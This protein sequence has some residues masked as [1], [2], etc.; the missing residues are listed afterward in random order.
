MKVLSGVRMFQSPRTRA[1]PS[2]QWRIPEVQQLSTV[3][4]QHRTRQ[5]DIPQGR[6]HCHT[7]GF[8]P[9]YIY[10]SVQVEEFVTH[11]DSNAGDNSEYL[12]EEGFKGTGLSSK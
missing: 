1:V 9:S 4:A 12:T 5:S 8:K 7:L 6:S 3:E 11:Y 2:P 10:F